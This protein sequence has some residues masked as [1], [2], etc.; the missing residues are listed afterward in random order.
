MSVRLAVEDA[1][2]AGFDHR[3]LARVIDAIDAT[4][5]EIEAEGARSLGSLR[6]AMALLER[7][8]RELPRHFAFE[9]GPGGSF[10]EA[11][12]RAPQ[13]EARLASLREDHAPLREEVA[14]LAGEARLAGTTPEAWA[15]VAT[16]FRGFAAALRRH[17]SAEDAVVAEALLTDEPA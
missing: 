12:L 3:E 13:L 11:L 2:V 5:H 15:G 16:R 9:A 14:R 6:H 8:D 4:L 1:A 17:E 10:A 7:L